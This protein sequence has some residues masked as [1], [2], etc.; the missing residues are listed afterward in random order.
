ML[1]LLTREYQHWT[2][3]PNRVIEL[4]LGCGNG[5][6][7]ERLAR[8]YPER[9]V[10]GADVMLSRLRKAERKCRRARVAN[11]ELWRAGAWPLLAVYLPDH[12]L[13]RVHVICPDPWPKHKHRANR[14]L[15]S[16]FCGRLATKLKP[17]GILHAAT[18]EPG[19]F[20]FIQAAIAPLAAY[21]PA[22]A[23]LADVA[24]LKSEFEEN[25]AAYGVAVRH[26]AWRV[27]PPPPAAGPGGVGERRGDA[28]AG[29][30]PAV[31]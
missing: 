13:D 29:G 3:P 30:G 16:E 27:S 22:P 23:G 31:T 25:F 21:V 17:D 7:L 9:L 6:F 4:D 18:D 12:C 19:Y 5:V 11:V 14:L 26:L 15:T 24:D 2:P 28:L 20:D 10:V 8:R 1:R